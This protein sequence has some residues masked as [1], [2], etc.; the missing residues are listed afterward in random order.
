MEKACLQ[1]GDI[2]VK[3][4][5]VRE[6]SMRSSEKVYAR[7]GSPTSKWRQ[8]RISSASEGLK[9]GIVDKQQEIENGETGQVSKG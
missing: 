2:W 7:G 6:R 5:V 3:N 1:E 8:Q 4:E 9:E